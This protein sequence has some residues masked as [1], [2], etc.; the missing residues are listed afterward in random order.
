MKGQITAGNT[1][2]AKVAVQWLKEAL[3]SYQ[4]FV[5]AE[6]ESL[7]NRHLRV[8]AKRSRTYYT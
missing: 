5:R 8:A 1:G 4:A 3:C 2:L 7:R 6:S